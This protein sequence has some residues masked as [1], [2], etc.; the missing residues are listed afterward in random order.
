[1][2]KKLILVVAITAFLTQ[3]CATITRGTTQE[4]GFT[5]IPSKSKV[6]VTT[7]GQTC[8]TPC[9]L[10]LKRNLTAIG[11]IS[12]EG[13]TPHAFVLKSDISTGGSVGLAGNLVFGGII[14]G[15]VDVTSGAMYDLEPRSIH[16]ELKKAK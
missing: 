15:A 7:S 14:G 12:H 11:T 4:V 13:Y 2:M 9:A 16:A 5:S 1:M 10:K 3:G 6:A 8:F